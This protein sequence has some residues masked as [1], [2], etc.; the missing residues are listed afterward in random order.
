MSK[1]NHLSYQEIVNIADRLTAEGKRVTLEYFRRDLGQETNSQ[2]EIFLRRWKQQTQKKNNKISKEEQV[3]DNYSVNKN[4]LHPAIKNK[5]S[6]QYLNSKNFSIK[7]NNFK[8][9]RSNKKILYNST[10][11]FQGAY[12]DRRLNIKKI[13]F[14]KSDYKIVNKTFSVERLNRESTIVKSLFLALYK[15]KN[16][17]L[18]TLETQKVMENNLLILRVQRESKI[19]EI[20]KNHAEKIAM[21]LSEFNQIQAMN[22]RK[23]NNLRQQLGL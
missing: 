2:I 10:R 11:K 12:K 7:S 21:L 19:C 17:R 15:V 13:N 18:N 14:T 22:N 4:S 6:L 1:E 5:Y 23:I 8:K 3:F 20:K 9:E 16:I